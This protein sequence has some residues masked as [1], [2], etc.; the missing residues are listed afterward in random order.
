[1][2]A[3]KVVFGV[4]AIATISAVAAANTGE[5]VEAAW[6]VGRGPCCLAVVGKSLFA[7]THRD[8]QL[9]QIDPST[10]KIVWKQSIPAQSIDYGSF[11]S[12]DGSLWILY[13]GAASGH[14]SRLDPMTHQ[15]VKVSGLTNPTFPLNGVDPSGLVVLDGSLWVGDLED[16]LIHRIDPKTARVSGQIKVGGVALTQLAAAAGGSLWLTQKDTT[17]NGL[18]R[19]DPATGR[20]VAHIQ[21][22]PPAAEVHTVATVGKALWVSLAIASVPRGRPTV[23][24]VDTD[25]N[26]VTA[27]LSPKVA[28][29]TDTFPAVMTAG[30]GT[31]WLQTTPN[32]LRQIDPKTGAP[33]KTL[34]IPLPGKRPLDDY[35]MSQ[36]AAGFGSNWVTTWPGQGGPT[37]PAVGSLL[38][39]VSG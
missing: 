19:V 39:F 27:K 31:L 7:G 16:N 23:F 4:V 17:Q 10:N 15:Q 26:R 2:F 13:L 28:G 33:I 5:K 8:A 21:P 20:V 34:T 1:M 24:R 11:V 6:R 25:T 36:I 3:R 9:I 22:F 37:D 18:Y 30:D 29:N 35:W 38:R 12:Y 32:A 14:V